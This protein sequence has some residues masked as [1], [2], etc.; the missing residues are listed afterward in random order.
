MRKNKINV[1]KT[2]LLLL[3][4][5]AIGIMITS[6]C[7]YNTDANDDI[8]TLKWYIPGESF[9][10]EALIMEKFNEKLYKKAGF[11]LDLKLI[12]YNIYSDRMNMIIASDNDFDLWF[13]GYLNNYDRMV[14]NESL[15]DITSMVENS[16][17][18]N[19][20]PEYVWD[21]ATIQNSIYAVPNM[22]VMFEQRCL[23]IKEDLA[24]KYDLDTSHIKKTE[25]I[26]Q[27]L[28]T[29]KE[30][31]PDIYPFRLSMH[32]FSF[33]SIDDYDFYD[34]VN[35]CAIWLD[36]NGKVQCMPYYERPD[37]KE[38]IY[39]LYD[40]FKKGYIR[41]DIA[42]VMSDDKDYQNG[43]YAVSVDHYKPGGEYEFEMT[44]NFEV[45]RVVVSQPYIGMNSPNSTMIGIYKKSK[46][47]EEAF[48]LI[49]IINSDKELYN[50]LVF[51][52]EGI[53]YD[54]LGEDRIT[55]KSNNYGVRAWS[56]GNQFNAYFIDEQSEDDWEITKKMNE[57][58]AISDFMGFH[59]DTSTIRNEIIRLDNIVEKYDVML[60][61]AQ[62][63]DTYWSDFTKEMEQSGMYKVCDEIKRQAEE[64]I[65]SKK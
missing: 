27:F 32:E 49:E 14:Q 50:M 6:S 12:D 15:Y 10:D 30:N 28:M 40:W 55:L 35:Y 61:G 53:H 65:Y 46:H 5:S 11:R 42:S 47:P 2:A 45:E 17:L 16:Y 29:V 26:E 20:M 54:K 36:D 38:R 62:D 3:F 41:K 13:V 64:F 22:Q 18:K 24:K 8:I 56:V 43:R 25:D 19:V 21:A 44:N 48:K 7:T 34:V 33:Q 51:G 63:P 57:E 59:V 58:T 9:R 4:I 1:I 39:K 23:L 31:E 52:L 37:Y 60:T